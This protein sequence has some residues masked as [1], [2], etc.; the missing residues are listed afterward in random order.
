ML[1]KFGKENE[2]NAK[3]YHRIDEHFETN[4]YEAQIKNRSQ[5]TKIIRFLN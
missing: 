4:N 1:E 5:S 3:V 2:V